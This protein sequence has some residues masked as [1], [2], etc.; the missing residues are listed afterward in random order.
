MSNPGAALNLKDLTAGIA[1]LDSAIVSAHIAP[2]PDAIGSSTALA[3]G[4]AR[5]GKRTSVYLADGVIEKMRPLIR[6][7]AVSN[8]IPD[9]RASAVLVVDT[10][11]K[12]RVGDFYA[13]LFTRGERVFNIDHHVS[14][15][16]WG[17]INYIDGQ[18][19][20]A[21]VIVFEILKELNVKFDSELAN[22]LYAG[23]I[24]DTGQFRYSNTD[25]RALETAA[26]LVELGAQPYVVANA[27]YYSVPARVQKLRALALSGIKLELGGRAAIVVVTKEIL[28]EAGAKDEDTEGLIDEARALEGTECAVLI[29]ELQLG[30]WKISLRSKRLDFDVNQIAGKFGGDGHVAAAGCKITGTVEEVRTVLLREIAAGL[31]SLPKQ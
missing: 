5:L 7:V 20:A 29:R 6:S 27:L 9:E 26:A 18:A 15:D 14:N 21:A 13:D 1:G 19:A 30:G 31:N 8:K 11:A 4:L 28:A 10:A 23:L 2:D 3:L 17:D 16:G 25:R 12:K 22:L 24:D